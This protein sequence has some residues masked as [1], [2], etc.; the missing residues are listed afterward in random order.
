MRRRAKRN[1]DDERRAMALLFLREMAISRGITFQ[2][3][4]ESILRGEAAHSAPVCA[5][6]RKST[7]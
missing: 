3:A 1:A 7:I 2:Q 5:T 4:C 6:E